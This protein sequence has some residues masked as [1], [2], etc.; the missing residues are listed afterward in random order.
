MDYILKGFIT[1]NGELEIELPQGIP[2]GEV[3]V[4]IQPRMAA[5]QEDEA[6]TG[7]EL[8]DLFKFE[9]KSGAEVIAFL[10]E[11]NGWWDEDTPDGLTWVEEV[12]RKEAE[13]RNLPKW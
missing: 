2:A 4:T 5:T 6:W 7:D 11:T 13:R 8:N 12:R 10:E 1:E 9:A 3:E